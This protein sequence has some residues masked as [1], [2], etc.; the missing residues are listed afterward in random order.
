MK[1]LIVGIS[2]ASGV[3]YAQRFLQHL[4]GTKKVEVHLIITSHARTIIRHEIGAADII[5]NLTCNNLPMCSTKTPIVI[6]L[7]SGR[8]DRKGASHV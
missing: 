1:P 3:I 4:A 2:G 5:R 6:P 7:C 8:K